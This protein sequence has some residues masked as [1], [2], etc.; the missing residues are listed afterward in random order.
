MSEVLADPA[1]PLVHA[2]LAL[3]LL[4]AITY[5]VCAARNRRRHTFVIDDDGEVIAELPYDPKDVVVGIDVA[6]SGKEMVVI[7]I[8]QPDGS[9]HITQVAHRT[10]DD[11]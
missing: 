10:V 11:E 2:A 7:G 9:L 6:P 4:A 5:G 8:R 1:F 3:A